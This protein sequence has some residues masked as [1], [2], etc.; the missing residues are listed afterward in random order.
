MKI[1]KNLDELCVLLAKE[2]GSSALRATRSESARNLVV[3]GIDEA[4]GPANTGPNA[5]KRR[6]RNGGLTDPN[7]IVTTT[8]KAK[9]NKNGF[10]V[11]LLVKNVAEGNHKWR[12]GINPCYKEHPD[13]WLP[14]KTDR[15]YVD[16][17]VQ[18]GR[19]Y[20][21]VHSEYYTGP[22]GQFGKPKPRDIYGK[23]GEKLTA[24]GQLAS[25]IAS[26]LAKRGW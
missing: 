11:E 9:A 20:S 4:L 14:L 10:V 18:S 25:L 8:E 12:G 6:G 7:L 5:Y 13:D 17:I 2:V 15:F 1:C 26:E 21:W 22:Q 3:Q 16:A 24:N 19:G 23:A